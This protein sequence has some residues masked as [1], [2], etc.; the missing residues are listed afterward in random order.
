[1]GA[2]LAI[3]GGVL[4]Y[5]LAPRKSR[6]KSPELLAAIERTLERYAGAKIGDRPFD[7]TALLDPAL[8]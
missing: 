3:V 5:V 4:V 8:F 1:M 2:A 6:S 7:P